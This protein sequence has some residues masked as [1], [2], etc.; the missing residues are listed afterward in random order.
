LLPFSHSSTPMN[1]GGFSAFVDVGYYGEV[2]SAKAGKLFPA[3]NIN[4]NYSKNLKTKLSFVK[5]QV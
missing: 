3:L 1:R 2:G 5:L 4:S